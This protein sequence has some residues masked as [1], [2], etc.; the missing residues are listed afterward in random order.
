MAP[1]YPIARIALVGALALTVPAGM[2][3]DGRI[4]VG[5]FMMKK[6]VCDDTLLC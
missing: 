4:G 1:P 2:H 3:G 6:Q 5:P